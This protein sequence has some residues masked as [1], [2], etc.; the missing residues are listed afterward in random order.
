MDIFGILNPQTRQA[1][2]RDMIP[3]RRFRHS[4]QQMLKKLTFLH[5]ENTY[6]RLQLEERIE[7]EK[8][9]SQRFSIT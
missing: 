6:K 9:L 5:Y 4:T 1:P 2:E 8:L 3:L 7:I